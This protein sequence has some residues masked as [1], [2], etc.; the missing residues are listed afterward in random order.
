[1]NLNNFTIKAQEVIQAA[2][3]AAYNAQ[4]PNIETAHL[5]RSPANAARLAESIA[6]FDAGGGTA[7]KLAG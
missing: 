5:L 6:E 1:M 4:N 7:R 3:Q 2:Q